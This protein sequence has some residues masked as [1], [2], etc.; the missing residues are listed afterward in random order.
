[1]SERV[2]ILWS[3]EKVVVG[4]FSSEATAN[5]FANLHKMID[6]YYIEQTR[7]DEPTVLL[8]DGTY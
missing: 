5:E 2:F 6:G 3:V 7:V 4:I 8:K 1:M